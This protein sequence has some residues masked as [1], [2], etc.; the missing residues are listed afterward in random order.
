M[1]KMGRDAQKNTT[2]TNRL[3]HSPHVSV[4]QVSK[5]AVD[6]S[7]MLGGSR[8]AEISFIDQGNA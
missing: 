3:A 2:L 4:L 7:L 1:D 8:A 6:N 5:P